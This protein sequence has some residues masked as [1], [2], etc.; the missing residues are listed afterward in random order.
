MNVY[1]SERMAELLEA[2]GHTPAASAEDADIVVLNTCHIQ[3]VSYN[4]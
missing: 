2:E 4:Y 3:C 1:D